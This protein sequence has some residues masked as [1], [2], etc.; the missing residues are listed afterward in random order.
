MGISPTT[1]YTGVL[2]NKK[3][4]SLEG[5]GHIVIKFYWLLLLLE[6]CNITPFRNSVKEENVIIFVEDA[7][8]EVEI[9]QLTLFNYQEFQNL[10]LV[11]YYIFY[12]ESLILLSGILMVYIYI[13]LVVINFQ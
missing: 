2:D 3:G 6:A 4:Q 5:T 9:D 1:R 11:G 8:K 10:L 12:Q 13:F 7:I